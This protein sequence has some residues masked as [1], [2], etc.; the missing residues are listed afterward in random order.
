[1][2]KIKNTKA[3][4]LLLKSIAAFALLCIMCHSIEFILFAW[5]YIGY[6]MYRISKI[7]NN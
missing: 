4:C 6:N 7:Y 1:M 5:G 2:K 3:I